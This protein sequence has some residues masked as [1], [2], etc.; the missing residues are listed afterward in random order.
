MNEYTNTYSYYRQWNIAGQL[1]VALDT[2]LPQLEAMKLTSWSAKLLYDMLL[3]G[4]KKY[5]TEPFEDIVL[6]GK[7]QKFVERFND[8]ICLMSHYHRY[9]VSRSYMLLENQFQHYQD[10]RPDLM[11]FYF[12]HC[13]KFN[14]HYIELY[15]A[16]VNGA[17]P[18]NMTITPEDIARASERIMIKHHVLKSM[19]MQV[20]LIGNTGTKGEGE[21]RHEE[22]KC[23]TTTLPGEQDRLEKWLV[24]YIGRLDRIVT[25]PSLVIEGAKKY[26]DMDTMDGMI[27]N[28]RRVTLEVVIPE[29]ER[30]F[31]GEKRKQQKALLEGY[32]SKLEKTITQKVITI[33][34]MKVIIAAKG[35][36]FVNQ[37][38][39]SIIKTR[40]W[41]IDQ[42]K[43]LYASYTELKNFVLSI[44]LDK[45][46]QDKLYKDYVELINKAEATAKTAAIAA[47]N[48]T[49]AL[50]S[51]V[52]EPVF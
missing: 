39:G 24:H 36:R 49:A 42:I 12:S 20:G 31:R 47:A 38:V 7:G 33:P 45:S 34:F 44:D 29:Y 1:V 22:K 25:D 14:D 30:Y 19:K 2:I 50:V 40:E 28:G 8:I 35:V 26:E 9:N 27:E 21:T 37:K 15:N 51:A 43:T 5:C 18:S 16:L 3:N 6:H 17:L 46:N 32:Q 10:C 23:R 11:R 4:L 41:C 48:E 52:A 13:C